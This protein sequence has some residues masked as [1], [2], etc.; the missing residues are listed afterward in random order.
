MKNRPTLDRP[1][2]D[3][4]NAVGLLRFVL[5]SLVILSHSFY[6]YVASL[7]CDPL[8]RLT[9]GQYTVGRIAVD[10][11]FVLSGFLVARSWESSR[12]W[13]DFLTRR[14]L[15]VYP[16]FLAAVVFTSYAAGPWLA[17]RGQARPDLPFWSGFLLPALML[18]YRELAM[19]GSLWTIRY[20][21]YYYLFIGLVGSAGL[22]A[23]RWP[24]L[25]MAAA[26]WAVY[27]AW[28]VS[29]VEGG[30]EDQHPRFLTGF[31]AGAACHAYRDRIP[32]SWAWFAASTAGLAWF[33]AGWA[34]Y[35]FWPYRVMSPAFPIFGTYALLF[36]ALRPRGLAARLAWLG[37]YSYGLYLYAY[38]IQV[39]L[40]TAYRPQLGPY[41]LFL[42]AWAIAGACAF[43]SLRLVERPALR[44]A[45][46]TPTTRRPPPAPHFP[47][48]DPATRTAATV[49]TAKG[50]ATTP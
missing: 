2:G 32:L 6:F 46:R 39:M 42:S 11:F 48:G 15:R 8:V 43:L 5:T 44:L 47:M 35:W 22:F 50:D 4:E 33:A 49:S 37:D 25:A 7:D 24:I 27:A 38:P 31:L 34:P 28:F 16:G 3:R 14:A 23:R 21:F 45:R 1:P 41:S 13:A 29:G 36:A 26:S 9:C 30:I 10:A 17:A 20:D 40:V 12:G 18:D 19:N